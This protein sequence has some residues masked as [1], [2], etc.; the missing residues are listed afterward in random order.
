MLR[1]TSAVFATRAEDCQILLD[2][3]WKA[4]VKL[5]GVS[6]REIWSEEKFS[7]A[8]K[9]VDLKLAHREPG[10]QAS[11]KSS[12]IQ[13]TQRR[14]QKDSSKSQQDLREIVSDVSLVIHLIP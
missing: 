7:A 14:R 3:E 5:G 10:R 1:A 6:G 11:K 12:A 2:R 9:T 8:K 13:A 4:D